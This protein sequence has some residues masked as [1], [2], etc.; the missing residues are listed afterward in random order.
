M[1]S[2]ERPKARD[3]EELRDFN[4][5]VCQLAEE[6]GK[7]V[8]ATGDVHFLD[9]EDEIY[10]HVLL[11]AKE[12]DDADKELPIYFRTTDEMLEEFSYLGEEK[13][14]EV[15]VKNPNLIAD[16]VSYTHLD[17]YKRQEKRLT[18]QTGA[19]GPKLQLILPP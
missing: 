7:P 4:R 12:F 3:E 14:Y 1:L 16:P 2:G 6:L 13:A 11:N 19:W 18:T 17:V 15:V 10:R 8:V 9:P 5:R